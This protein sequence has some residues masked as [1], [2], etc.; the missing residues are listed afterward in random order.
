M[1]DGVSDVKSTLNL[2]CRSLLDL[3]L[4]CSLSMGPYFAGSRRSSGSRAR[5]DILGLDSGADQ[6]IHLI[7]PF[8][9][10]IGKAKA[11]RF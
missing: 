1:E 5:E 2:L 9:L 7:L 3:S 6:A 10:H 8:G 4:M 11:G